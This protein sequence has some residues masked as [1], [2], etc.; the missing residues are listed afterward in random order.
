M[1]QRNF[2]I[3]SFAIFNKAIITDS[4]RLRGLGDELVQFFLFQ[5]PLDGADEVEHGKESQRE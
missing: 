3:D 2:P 4:V 5:S 1:L